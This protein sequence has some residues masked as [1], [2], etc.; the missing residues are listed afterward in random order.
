[1]SKTLTLLALV[2]AFACSTQS[3]AMDAVRAGMG[4]SDPDCMNKLKD[5]AWSH[6]QKQA[7]CRC[8][9]KVKHGHKKNWKEAMKHCKESGNHAG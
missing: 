4:V 9:A 5:E 2:T 1:M 7:R 6:A 3:Y 8:V